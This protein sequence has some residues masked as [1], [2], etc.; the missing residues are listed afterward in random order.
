M[1]GLHE[2]LCVI[3]DCGWSYS[4]KDSRYSIEGLLADFITSWAGVSSVCS[5]SQAWQKFYEHTKAATGSG[6][7]ELFK[8]LPVSCWDTSWPQELCQTVN[9]TFFFKLQHLCSPGGFLSFPH[10][11]H[12]LCETWNLL[13]QK[14]SQVHL[15]PEE[16][17][18]EIP[19]KEI[20]ESITHY[21]KNAVSLQPSW[22]KQK[23]Q[24]PL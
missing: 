3:T 8:W 22:H 12:C 17:P 9:S 13:F 2:C 6:G 7:N 20:N 23:N 4:I 18:S 16:F 10:F 15:T 24:W 5:A 21:G 11:L 1:Y 19:N 14:E